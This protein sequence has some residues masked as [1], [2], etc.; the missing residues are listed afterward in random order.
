[1]NYDLI[2]VSQSSSNLIQMTQNCI[3]SALADTK[4]INVI[5]VESGQ[6]YKYSGV[7]KFIEYNGVFNYNRALNIGLKYAKGDVYILANNDLIFKPGWSKIGKLMQLNGYH[8]ASAREG[9]Q[10]FPVTDTAYEGYNI[11]SLLNGWCIFL[12]KYC[13]DTIGQL[14][15]TCSFWYSD[16]LYACQLKAAGIKHALF[17]N[18]QVDHLVSKTLIK[19]TSRLKRQFMT[20]EIGKFKQRERYYAE[21]KRVYEVNP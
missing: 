3:D 12:D 19:Q 4:D 9:H 13:L 8:S 2:I 1:M 17:C 20:S 11:G 21:G 6:P 14:D 7:N 15:E 18:C 5:I 10:K 16:N